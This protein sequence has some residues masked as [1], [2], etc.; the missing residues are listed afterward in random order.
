MDTRAQGIDAKGGC[1]K[2]TQGM[3]T[4][5]G[6]RGWTQRGP[7]GWVKEGRGGQGWHKGAQ[8]GNEG[9]GTRGWHKGDAGDGNEGMGTRGW[10]QGGHGMAERGHGME[11]GGRRGS[12]KG[13]RS[14]GADG[15]GGR[16]RRAGHSPV[17][18]LPAGRRSASGCGDGERRGEGSSERLGG[19]GGVPRGCAG[20][21]WDN[22]SP[23]P[24]L[25]DAAGLQPSAGGLVAVRQKLPCPLVW[26]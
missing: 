4:G 19:A 10:G 13:A 26:P 2:G 21:C 25:W 14:R 24:P 17:D 3:D 11:Q 16:E 22:S 7:G 18:M 12:G 15:A 6:H 20:C 1:V 23:F 5:W 8:D 9:M